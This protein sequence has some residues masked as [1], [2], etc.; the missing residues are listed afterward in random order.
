MAPS[1]VAVS[2]VVG[3]IIY[4]IGNLFFQRALLQE[5]GCGAAA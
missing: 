4:L 3:P 5:K 2:I 1:M